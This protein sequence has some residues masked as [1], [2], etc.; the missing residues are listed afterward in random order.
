MLLMAAFL[1]PDTTLAAS[2]HII[3]RQTIVKALLLIAAMDIRQVIRF[4]IL[5]HDEL[6]RVGEINL[7]D[8]VGTS[9]VGEANRG[10]NV[11]VGCAFS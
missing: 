5:W 3:I 8:L 1:L 10:A 2:L 6:V 9:C 4:R 7:A 11:V